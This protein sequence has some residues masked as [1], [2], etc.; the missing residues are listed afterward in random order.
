MPEPI[1]TLRTK[2]R[3]RLRPQHT[4]L[5]SEGQALGVLEVSRNRAGMIVLGRYQPV[6][7][8][9]LLLR[10]DPGLLRAQ[11][12]LWTEDREWLGSSLRW[13]IGRRQIDVWTGAKP[14]RIVPR[15]GLARGWRVIAARTGEVARI[16]TPLVGRSS[17]IEQYRKMDQELLVFCYFLGSLSLGESLLPTTLEALGGGADRVPAPIKG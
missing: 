11:F 1:Q 8:E 7:G 3:G 13:H 12:S 9:S 6:E 15:T 4:I 14:Y 16:R 17:V 2:V 10:R 5:D